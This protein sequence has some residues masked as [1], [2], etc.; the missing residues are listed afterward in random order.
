[1][2]EF[3]PTIERSDKALIIKKQD[4]L[5]KDTIKYVL[6]NSAFYQDHFKVNKL[7]VED[8]NSISELNKIPPIS[9]K[10]LQ[11]RN[12]D[13]WC[14]P[15]KQIVDYCNT[16]G[17][18][19]QPV[20]IPLTKSDL[21]RLAYNEAIS[22]ACAEGSDEDIYQLST[23]ID[24]RFMAGLAYAQGV[25]AL[26]AGLVRVGPAPAELQ[27]LNIKEL[28][29][30]TLIIV[31][32]FLVKLIDYAE[33]NHIDYQNSSIKKAVCIGES[34]RDDNLKLNALGSRIKEKWD[35]ELFSTYASTEMGTAFTECK[36]GR[37]GH[38]HPELIITEIIDEEGNNVKDGEFGELTITTL[39]VE[40][41]PLIRF[42]TGDICRKFTDPCSC[43]RTTSRLGPLLGRKNQMI[44][45]KGTT[46]YPPAIFNVLDNQEFISL[47]C[48][49]VYSDELGNDQIRVRFSAERNFDLKVLKEQFSVNIRAT[50][51]LIEESFEDLYRIIHPK[52]S[53]KPVKYF[54]FRK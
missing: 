29:P 32:S 14:A 31:P 20:T 38:E 51:M 13:F 28:N 42:R 21:D 6:E 9:K 23:T 5:L 47:Y 2:K 17:T 8:I 24:R 41:M 10:D 26:G 45:F 4:D 33:R 49:E 54:D 34:I 25:I 40:G 46:I 43:G 52:N 3:D 7:N 50:P 35:I 18:E 19:G 36:F 12:K 27:W 15:A 11:S 30:T 39:G 48:I 37:G 44:K 53:R 22:L 1:M 16:S